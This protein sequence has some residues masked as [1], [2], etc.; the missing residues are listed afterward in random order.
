MPPLRIHPID[1]PLD[2]KDIHLHLANE[3]LHD[4]LHQLPEAFTGEPQRPRSLPISEPLGFQPSSDADILAND[5]NKPEGNGLGTSD[6]VTQNENLSLTFPVYRTHSIGPVDSSGVESEELNVQRPISEAQES[7]EPKS[8]SFP[9]ISEAPKKMPEH[10]TEETVPPVSSS[11]EE[12]TM[13]QYVLQMLQDEISK[14]PENDNSE[15]QASDVKAMHSIHQEMNGSNV[16]SNP[17]ASC[18]PECL[19]LPIR[20]TPKSLDMTNED[21]ST[22]EPTLNSPKVSVIPHDLFY[23]PHYDVPISEV[24]DAFATPGPDPSLSENNKICAELIVNCLTENKSLALGSEDGVPEPGQRTK[25]EVMPKDD[26]G[27]GK[28]KKDTCRQTKSSLNNRGVMVVPKSPPPA[29]P[30]PKG[31]THSDVPMVK[32]ILCLLKCE[33]NGSLMSLTYI[34]SPHYPLGLGFLKSSQITKLQI[35]NR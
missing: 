32:C 21:G 13:H 25:E 20:N 1:S 2:H 26:K 5:V 16:K 31:P 9:Q 29:L 12:E 6:A 11:W 18:L 27:P 22:A 10:L 17:E 7:L 4:N 19:S 35:M 23:Y 30:A 15:K 28:R 14:L 33:D 3:G 8:G 34:G 24:L